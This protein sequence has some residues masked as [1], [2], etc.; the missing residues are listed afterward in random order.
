MR[1]NQPLLR[2][3]GLAALVCLQ[4]AAAVPAFAQEG[5]HP[6]TSPSPS[7]S[8]S[9]SAAVALAAA[10][11]PVASP[12]AAEVAKKPFKIDWRAAVLENMHNKLIHF[13]IALGIAAA[14][15]ILVSPRWPQHDATSQILLLVAALFGIA[16]YFTGDAQLADFRNSPLH[17]AAELHETLG[18]STIS[19]LWL[20]VVLMRIQAVKRWLWI[21]AILLVLLIS[22]TGFVGGV[23]AHTDL[24]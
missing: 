22:A 14:V 2:A 1:D 23:V 11:S 3:R 17:D 9:P 4:L 5:H 6:E 21:Y 19:G 18:I 13:P 7:P 12:A 16:A 24:P 15:L 20:G 10:P 8:L